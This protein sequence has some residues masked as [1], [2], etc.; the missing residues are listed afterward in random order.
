YLP[1]LRA[2]DRVR[3]ATVPGRSRLGLPGVVLHR[4]RRS[5]V[6]RL[7]SGSRVQLWSA[8]AQSPGEHRA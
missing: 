2:D 3:A 8:R 6:R 7:V 1:Q 4:V 5:D